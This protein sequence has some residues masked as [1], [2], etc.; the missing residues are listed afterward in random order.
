MNLPHIQLLPSVCDLLV[1]GKEQDLILCPQAPKGLQGSAGSVLV[2]VDQDVVHDKGYRIA[3][4]QA[5]L[6]GGQPKGQ[7]ELIPGAVAHAF[8][9]NSMAC[10]SQPHN[11]L[12][13]FDVH[14]SPQ[15][16]KMT[17]GQLHEVL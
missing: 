4:F 7:E 1:M 10:V 15:A 16:H 12:P 3:F 2:K 17:P 5:V 13:V 11:H 14:V 6:Q 8:H 9:W